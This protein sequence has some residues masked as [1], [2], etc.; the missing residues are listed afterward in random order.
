[1][2]SKFMISGNANNIVERVVSLDGLGNFSKGTD[3]TR[4]LFSG[5]IKNAD[6]MKVII[7]NEGNTVPLVDEKQS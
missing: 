2:I 4:Y 3:T 1:M 6:K 7:T 5:R